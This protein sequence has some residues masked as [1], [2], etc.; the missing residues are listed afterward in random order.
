MEDR[1]GVHPLSTRLRRGP[2]AGLL[3]A[4][5]LAAPAGA[6]EFNP[7]SELLTAFD[8]W[9]AGRVQAAWK[10]LDGL[11]KQV[12]NFRLA[13]L[14]YGELLAARAGAPER[15][16]LVASREPEVRELVEEARLRL[17]HWRRG[18]DGTVPDAV[19][20]LSPKTRY[21]VVV[22]LPLARL[23]VLENSA[24]GPRVLHH[25]YAAMGRNGFGKQVAGD[26]R[27]PL[28]VYTVTGFLRD[29]TLPELYGAG[30][31]PLNYPNAWD[32]R[33]NKTGN[34]IWLHGVPR[35]TYSRAPRS[36]EGCV[37]VANSDLVSLKP[38]LRQGQTP[39]VLTD[40]LGWQRPAD[41]ERERAELTR[42]LEEWRRAWNAKDTN[43]YLSFYADDFETDGMDKQAFANYKQRVNAAKSFIDVR[44]EDLDL[45]RYPDARPMAVARFRQDYRSD[46]YSSSAQ[47]EQYWRRE[48]DGRWRIVKEASG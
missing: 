25:Y 10:S 23:Y 46:N 35:A 21:A 41:R 48:G 1:P 24:D 45:L 16:L 32:Q 3:F 22:D 11:V 18:E 42:T 43:R 17:G 7:E 2:L 39:V 37:T 26:N 8:D 20:G 40:R 29:E 14:L 12:P 38:Y 31:F 33:L 34:G 9:Q 47:K 4:L 13:Q 5:A 28:G 44:V 6:A 36:S 30:A 15:N 19:L 27:T